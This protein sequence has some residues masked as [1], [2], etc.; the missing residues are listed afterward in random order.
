MTIQELYDWAVENNVEN[1]E[2]VTYTYYGEH[3]SSIQ[4]EIIKIEGR[5]G[6]GWTMVEL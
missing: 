5:N 4:P 3:T 1:E 2:I 6:L